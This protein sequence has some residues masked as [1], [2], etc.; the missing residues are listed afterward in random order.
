MGHR[1]FE[2]VTLGVEQRLDISQSWDLI[3]GCCIIGRSGSRGIRVDIMP[4][5]FWSGTYREA[6]SAVRG[7]WSQQRGSAGMATHVVTPRHASTASRK[8]GLWPERQA[9]TRDLHGRSPS[10][11]MACTIAA[12]HGG[13]LCTVNAS[14]TWHGVRRVAYASVNHASGRHTRLST[15][16]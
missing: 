3:I 5:N 10:G 12:A 7:V 9:A 11:A 4:K 16:A 2:E 13:W 1:V 14:G 15:R 8:S 6:C